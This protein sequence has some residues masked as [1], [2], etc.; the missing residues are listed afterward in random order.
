MK[1]Q[2]FSWSIEPKR[3]FHCHKFIFIF[4]SLLAFRAEWLLL[5]RVCVRASAAITM[6]WQTLK[7]LHFF[8]LFIRF[9]QLLKKYNIYV[10]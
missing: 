2:H 9:I 6:R 5:R 7:A 3:I 8:S 10:K 1:I 4:F